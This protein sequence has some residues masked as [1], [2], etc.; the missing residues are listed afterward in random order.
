MRN[1]SPVRRAVD[2][3]GRSIITAGGLA[4]IVSILAIFF[5]IF[6]EV[7]PLATVPTARLL[8]RH[9]IPSF[10]VAQGPVE[11]G[12]DEHRELGFVLGTAG[13]VIQELASGKTSLLP[14]PS[15][16][17]HVSITALASAGGSTGRFLIGTA[18][19]LVA[20]V[21]VGIATLF[22]EDG[23][24]EKRPHFTA[25]APLPFAKEAIRL[26][27][28]RWGDS[29]QAIAAVT[30]SGAL[31]FVKLPVD[32]T[33]SRSA[34]PQQ[35]RGV[36]GRITA[37]VLDASLSSLYVGTDQGMLYHV[38][39]AGTGAPRLV[40][41]V[42][43]H[44]SP[45][46]VTRLGFLNGDRSVVVTTES[47][48]V[49]IWGL[50]KDPRGV[51]GRS[52]ARMHSLLSHRSAIT[53]FGPSRRDK[54]FVTADATGQISVHHA[55][56]EQTWLRL[57][58]GNV[59]V[60]AVSY[61]PK[62]DGLA[63]LDALG[64]L[65]FFEVRNPYPEITWRTLFH[66]V[67]YEGYDRPAYVWQSSSGSDEFEPKYSLMPLAFGTLKGT[68]YALFLAVPLAIGGAIFTS[69]FMHPTLRAS[70]KPVIEIM[71][72]LPTVVLGF[73]AGLWLAPLLERVFPAL[74]LFAMLAPLLI[75]A[76]SWAWH[77]LPRRF[78]QLI[79]PGGES[80][81]LIPPL[82]A[83]ALLC[84][85]GNTSIEAQF[86]GGDFRRWVSDSFGVQ[87]DQ[88]N[89]V[90]VGLVMGFAIIPIIYSIA[91]EA[92]SNVP[93]NLI[94]GSLALGATRWQT[95]VHLVLLAASP[96]IFSA[97]M[98]GF[99]RAIGETMIVLMATGN[100]PILDWSWTNGFRTLSANIAVEIPEAPYGGALYRVLFLA[101]LLLFIVTF[102]INTAAELVRQRLRDKYASG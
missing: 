22:L 48:Q 74:L 76:V 42:R 90:V 91:E 51:E 36:P 101:S 61:A 57:D 29:G 1:P 102:I 38:T 3:V 97:I 82:V 77:A 44:D 23:H 39:L 33:G 11:I 25:G 24:R 7:T 40:H 46:P 56:A 12:M 17:G 81:L 53:A 66:P 4:V 62:S 59:P 52:L 55:T 54:S 16:L 93:K 72:A 94:A 95:A 18:E 89:A 75:V 43:I 78:S 92:L 30:D 34:V 35:V 79:R 80:L 45:S 63:A 64:R 87:Y 27:A 49:S 69:Q 8:S 41:S 58:A 2:H 9:T 85:V 14:L 86:F 68:L 84:L 71:A 19:G 6:R 31:L 37:L 13:V 67:W 10:A 21:K 60:L 100:T 65:S 88:R 5:F 73:V 47:G 50:I 70:I 98:I 83:L 28:Y 32:D 96:G 26:L 99:G 15:E 20:P